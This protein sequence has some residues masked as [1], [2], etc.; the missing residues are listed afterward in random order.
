MYWF[1]LADIPKEKIFLNQEEAR[2]ITKVLRYGIG[3]TIYLNDGKGSV[4]QC[5]IKFIDKK[6]CE[7]ESI[8]VKYHPKKE[9]FVHIAI[10]P[11]KNNSRF[12]WFLEKATEIGIDQITPIYSNHSE[13]RKIQSARLNKVLIGAL[14]QSCQAYLPK[15]NEPIG[16][17][18]FIGNSETSNSEKFIAAFSE[19]NQ[20]LRDMYQKSENATILIGPEGDF[21]KEEIGLALSKGFTRV[22]L[23]KSRLRTETAGI[24]ACHTISLINQ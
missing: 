16:F 20:E 15:L 8:A 1:Y 5:I 18:D 11:T 23:G 24:V 21:D 14:K 19:E 12:E 17:N 13:R 22:N 3:D 6:S 2:H 4:Y 9:C 10:A 7:L